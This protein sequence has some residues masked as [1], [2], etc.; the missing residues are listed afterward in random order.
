MTEFFA[1]GLNNVLAI[2]AL[3]RLGGFLGLLLLGLGLLG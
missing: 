3:N 1:Q 2:I